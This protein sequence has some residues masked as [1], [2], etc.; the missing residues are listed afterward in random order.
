[1]I[2]GIIKYDYL[3]TQFLSYEISTKDSNENIRRRFAEMH[4]DGHM[5]WGNADRVTQMEVA[6]NNWNFA[7]MM[8][9]LSS[10]FED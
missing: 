4:A 1:M 8:E 5:E 2:N 3:K 9:E 10:V 6:Y 7:V